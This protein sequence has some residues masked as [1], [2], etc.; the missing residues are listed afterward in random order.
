MIGLLAMTSGV[1]ITGLGVCKYVNEYMRA[2][3]QTTTQKEPKEKS[4]KE[5]QKESQ[6]PRLACFSSRPYDM[7]AS[8]C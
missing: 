1:F 4:Q 8:Q 3:R 2:A 7:P 6:W 5:S